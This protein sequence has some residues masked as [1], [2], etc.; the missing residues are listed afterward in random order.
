[1]IR[2][3]KLEEQILDVLWNM[4]KAFPKDIIDHL[5]ENEIPYNTILS[6]IRKLEKKGYIGF[7]RYGKAHQ[8]YPI[9]EKKEY[10][11]SLFKKLYNGLL[12][13]SSVGLLSHF[14][15]EENIDIEELEK[16]VQQIRDQENE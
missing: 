6:S 1:M 16:I 3:T 11:Q 15:Q 12:D 9:L 7:T 13:R 14:M 8:Y 4:E 10:S 2:L 5:P